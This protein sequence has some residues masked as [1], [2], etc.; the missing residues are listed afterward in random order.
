M[1]IGT[2][3]VI[4]GEMAKLTD[5]KIAKRD[6]TVLFEGILSDTPEGLYSE[7]IN[8]ITSEPM[9]NKLIIIVS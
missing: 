6:N 8:Y 2:F 3:I 5:V 4:Q 9:E 1:N 7:E